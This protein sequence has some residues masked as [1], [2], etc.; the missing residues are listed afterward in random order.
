MAMKKLCYAFFFDVY[1]LN[2]NQHDDTNEIYF[3]ITI[4]KIG[5]GVWEMFTK[6]RG[7]NTHR[8]DEKSTELFHSRLKLG[9]KVQQKR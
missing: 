2:N 5:I 7:K 3:L 9:R 8:Q 6:R 1:T 4:A